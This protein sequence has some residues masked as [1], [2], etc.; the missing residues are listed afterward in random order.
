MLEAR[1]FK[2]LFINVVA[3]VAGGVIKPSK[4]APSSVVKNVSSFGIA[5]SSCPAAVK[6]AQTYDGCVWMGAWWSANR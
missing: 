3:I 1:S 6:V 5:A 2:D 4:G